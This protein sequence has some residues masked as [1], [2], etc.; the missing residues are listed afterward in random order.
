MIVQQ[1]V[2]FIIATCVASQLHADCI[3]RE[4]LQICTDKHGNILSISETRGDHLFPEAI[5]GES[6]WEKT[7]DAVRALGHK[8]LNS[9]KTDA[10]DKTKSNQS[11]LDINSQACVLG[12]L[13]STC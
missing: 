9:H 1:K 2:F 12:P 4:N 13:G 8:K 7:L 5:R 3:G 11:T 10:P 6:N